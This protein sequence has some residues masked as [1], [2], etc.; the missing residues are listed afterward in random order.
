MSL[1]AILLGLTLLVPLG[2][3]CGL[4]SPFFRDR[5]PR[6]LGLAPMP[7]L[8]AAMFAAHGVPVQIPAPLRVT[9]QLDLPAAMLLG[10]AA[11]L[12]SAA[13]FYAA[14]Y[15][16]DDPRLRVFSAWWLLTLAGSLG[17]FIVVD[18]AGFYLLFALVS[19]SAYGLISHEQSARSDRAASVYIGLAVAG[20]AFL[21]LAFVMLAAGAGGGSTLIA[22][23]VAALP[24]SPTRDWTIALLVLGFALKMG[25]APVHVWL[26]L[27][28]PA[29]PMPASA[30][31]SGVVV[32]AGVIGLIRF[33]PLGTAMPE[34]GDVLIVAGFITAFAGVLIGITQTQ[35]KTVLAYSTVSQMGLVAVIFGAGLGLGSDATADVAAFYALHHLLVKGS[36]FMAVGVVA[37]TAPYRFW[38]VL[39]ITG[40]LALSLAG[41]PLTGGAAAK[42]AMKPILGDG[43]AKML[44][45]LAAVGSTML[46]LHFLFILASKRVS[47]GAATGPGLALSLPWL[48]VSVMAVILPWALFAPVTG[49]PASTAFDPDTLFTAAW[50]IALGVAGA[51]VLRLVESRVPR[52]PEGDIIELAR[53]GTPAVLGIGRWVVRIDR[54]LTRWPVA[55]LMLLAVGVS[56]GIGLFGSF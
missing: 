29:A 23:A 16:R 31:L 24:Q 52:I 34:W 27:A 18:I 44:A 42:L 28:H 4:L 32:K 1:T 17:T 12:W 10:G 6:L 26:P 35:P 38:A 14:A 55:V 47:D 33:L 46:V 39:M 40:F 21:L 54:V 13:G 50:P 8:L 2:L 3:A 19:L 43:F 48:A 56:V 37:A 45:T 20:E 30:V 11:L 5:V 22:D 36:L 7:G 9:L 53:F 49:L 51:A 41:L 15:L 25:L